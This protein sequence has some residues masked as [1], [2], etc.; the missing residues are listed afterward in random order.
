MSKCSVWMMRKSKV[1]YWTLFCPKYCAAAGG[2]QASASATAVAAVHRIRLMVSSD[3]P[4]RLLRAPGRLPRVAPGG[5]TLA[6]QDGTRGRRNPSNRAT[7]TG[8]V[9]VLSHYGE[10][11]PR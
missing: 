4:G 9:P 1:R 8:P 6:V 11:G 3:P 2:A 10:Q 5:R 7:H